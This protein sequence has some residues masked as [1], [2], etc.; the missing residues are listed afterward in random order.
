VWG[1]EEGAMGSIAMTTSAL[2]LSVLMP[3][4]PYIF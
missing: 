3:I 2:F 4:L 1:E